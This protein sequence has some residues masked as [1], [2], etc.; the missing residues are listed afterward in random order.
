MEN[1]NSLNLNNNY[2]FSKRLK[3][4]LKIDFRRI[5]TQPLLY[6]MLII[7]LVIPIL[8]LI[9]TSMVEGDSGSSLNS[10]WQAI[11]STSDSSL[12]SMDITSMCN[13]NLIY[14]VIAILVATFIADDFRSGFSKNIFSIRSKKTDY[15]ISKTTIL[16][17]GGVLMLLFYFLG[18]II[19]GGIAGLSFQLDGF[20]IGNL[21]MCLISKLFLVGIFIGIFAFISYICKEKLWLSILLCLSIGMLLFMIVPMMTPLNQT[22]LN[23]FLCIG[24][25]ILFPIL[26]GFGSNLILNKTSLI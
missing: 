5:F 3:S 8:V 11:G 22:I 1:V 12:M 25:G 2:T 18:A 14:F 17:I 4:M 21:I 16:F 26:I 10:V 15:V 9:M 19:G 7:S 6:I 20:G 13:I 23:L 24:G